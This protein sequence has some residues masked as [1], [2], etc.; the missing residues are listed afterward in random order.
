[1]PLMR[2]HRTT[3]AAQVWPVPAAHACPS[4]RNSPITPTSILAPGPNTKVRWLPMPSTTRQ[5]AIAAAV[6]SAPSRRGSEAIRAGRSFPAPAGAASAGRSAPRSPTSRPRASPRSP[7]GCAR[8]GSAPAR[9]RRAARARR[10]GSSPRRRRPTALVEVWHRPDELQV[11]VPRGV[12]TAEPVERGLDL[13][14]DPRVDVGGCVDHHAAVDPVV[15][16]AA[17]QYVSSPPNEWPP[18]TTRSSPSAS[19]SPRTS[20]A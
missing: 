11:R 1:M 7:P 13:L 4:A 16:F 17:S 10:R 8:A 14:H 19:S 6:R 5:S 2:P 9:S 20:R 12:H 15:W 3:V 18:I